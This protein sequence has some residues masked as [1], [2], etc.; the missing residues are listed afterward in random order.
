MQKW[1]KQG[2]IY[3]NGENRAQIPT[4][5]ELDK[6]TWR[7]FFSEKNAAGQSLTRYIDVAAGDPSKILYEAKEPI[8]DLGEPGAF[9]VSGIMPSWALSA[10]SRWSGKHY[11][12]YLY[13]LGWSCRSDVPYQISIG[14][15]A[16]YDGGK[17]FRKL[18][19]GPIPV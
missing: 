13:Y 4:L 8:L 1:K 3:A 2:L 10:K 12:M 18:S 6:K 17:T 5:L 9:D 7:I 15:A 11:A 14:A 16:S 19:K